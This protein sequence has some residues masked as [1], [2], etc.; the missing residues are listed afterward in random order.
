MPRSA[1]IVP[2]TVSHLNTLERMSS[3]TINEDVPYGWEQFPALLDLDLEGCPH[4]SECIDALIP[5]CAQLDGEGGIREVDFAVPD[6]L[7]TDADWKRLE[8]MGM[9]WLVQEHTSELQALTA[10]NLS[11][12]GLTEVPPRCFSSADFSC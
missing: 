12:L 2:S 8:Q 6:D 11:G 5:I 4:L 1:L 3:L 10:L 9:L 7:L